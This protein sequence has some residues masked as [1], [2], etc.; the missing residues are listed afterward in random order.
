MVPLAQ[1]EFSMVNMRAS[2]RCPAGAWTPQ[3]P[4]V[5]ESPSEDFPPLC[6]PSTQLPVNRLLA[7][8]KFNIPFPSLFSFVQMP[9]VPNV[10]SL[11]WNFHGFIVSV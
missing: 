4:V 10:V 7:L 11:P 8:L 1:S 5:S 3:R 2:S 6:L 9:Y